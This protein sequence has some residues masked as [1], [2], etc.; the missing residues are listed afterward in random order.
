MKLQNTAIPSL[1]TRPKFFELG[2]GYQAKPFL[3]NNWFDL[4]ESINLLFL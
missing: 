2:S 3:V 1:I 4:N